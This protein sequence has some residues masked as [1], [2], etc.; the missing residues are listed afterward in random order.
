MCAAAGYEVVSSAAAAAAGGGG[1]DGGAA[2]AATADAGTSKSGG[3]SS[4]SSSSSSSSKKSDKAK[5]KTAKAG[6][7]KGKDKKKGQGGSTQDADEFKK[8]EAWMKRVYIVAFVGLLLHFGVKVGKYVQTV[9]PNKT[10]LPIKLNRST[11]QM[12][13]FY[14]SSE[15]VLPIN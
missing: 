6:K 4:S 3:G 7:G 10:V 2:T 15:T 1:F 5:D 12:K 9:L 14:L 13:P 8:A 11:Y